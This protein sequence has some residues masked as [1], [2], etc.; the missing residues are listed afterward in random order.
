PPHLGRGPKRHEHPARRLLARPPQGHA[1]QARRPR[2]GAEAAVDPRPLAGGAKARPQNR[3]GH[4]SSLF[5]S[6]K[7]HFTTKGH[8]GSGSTTGRSA[9]HA[10]E[11]RGRPPRA[12]PPGSPP[13][14]RPAPTS[15]SQ[16]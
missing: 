12:R 8:H 4:K 14:A 9:A 6:G 13:S 16:R 15:R 7:G 3:H 10:K 2:H 5:G 1:D 11:P